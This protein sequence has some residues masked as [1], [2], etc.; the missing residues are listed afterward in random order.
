ML[1]FF[2]LTTPGIVITWSPGYLSW[3]VNFYIFIFFSETVWPI[4]TKLGRNDHWMVLYK[5]LFVDQKYTN[6]TRGPY[7]PK[8]VLFVFNLLL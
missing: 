8:R 5:M 3:L 4:G 2:S 6:E 7:V 1:H